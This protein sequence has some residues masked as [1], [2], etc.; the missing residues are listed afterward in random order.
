MF[1]VGFGFWD[2]YFLPSLERL[3]KLEAQREARRGD[4]YNTFFGVNDALSS[5]LDERL[6]VHL[7]FC[8]LICPT[9]S[10]TTQRFGK[11]RERND[12]G[13]CYRGLISSC[14]ICATWKISL[15]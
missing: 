2:L 13:A 8:L 12:S 1:E 10:A 14:T 5:V 9:R 15:G 3:L 11:N 6:C 7:A 4:Y